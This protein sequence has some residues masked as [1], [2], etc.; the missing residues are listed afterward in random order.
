[1]IIIMVIYLQ[2]WILIPFSVLTTETLIMT[3]VNLLMENLCSTVM[4]E[5]RH[6]LYKACT[7]L[8]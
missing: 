8:Y 7:I 3:P 5:V 6:A 4:V 2:D 1:M